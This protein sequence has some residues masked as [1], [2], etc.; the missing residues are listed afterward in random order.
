VPFSIHL[1]LGTMLHGA[2]P[3]GGL[4]SAGS[5]WCLGVILV[6]P[7]SDQKLRTTCTIRWPKKRWLWCAV[8]APTV[9]QISPARLC[10]VSWQTGSHQH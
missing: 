6:C 2:L 9:Q 8:W 7:T 4:K 1:V 3:A 10:G 5:M